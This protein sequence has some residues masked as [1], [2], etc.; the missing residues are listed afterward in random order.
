MIYG[1]YKDGASIQEEDKINQACRFVS[2]NN[3]YTVGVSQLFP[4]VFPTQKMTVQLITD[5]QEIDFLKDKYPLSVAG[6]DFNGI[7]QMKS[8]FKKDNN[9]GAYHNLAVLKIENQSI[10]TVHLYIPDTSF[11]TDVH[12]FYDRFFS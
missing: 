3:N 4:I 11:H 7:S 9:L 2:S 10:D 8:D 5:S 6:Y 1:N 12:F